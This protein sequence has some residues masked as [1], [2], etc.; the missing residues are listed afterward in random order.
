MLEIA[1]LQEMNHPMIVTCT[2]VLQD[3]KCLYIIQELCDGGKR[4]CYLNVQ[5]DN[6][7]SCFLSLQTLQCSATDLVHYHSQLLPAWDT[8]LHLLVS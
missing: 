4:V 8:I 6:R 2:T 5:C 7:R 3:P 1:L